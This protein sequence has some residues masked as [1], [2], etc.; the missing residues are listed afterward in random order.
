[1]FISEVWKLCFNTFSRF[2]K[3]QYWIIKIS[4]M[5]GHGVIQDLIPHT[6][7]SPKES[8]DVWVVSTDALQTSEAKISR[9][10]NK[11]NYLDIYTS[12]STSDPDDKYLDDNLI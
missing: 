12:D 8:I 4:K 5:G 10:R 2:F 7:I 3:C 11:H 9:P 6:D 1:M